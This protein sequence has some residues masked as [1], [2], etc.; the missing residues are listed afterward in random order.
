MRFFKTRLS[1]FRII[2]T[3][4]YHK[5]K[6]NVARVFIILQRVFFKMQ[7]QSKKNLQ[8]SKNFGEILDKIASRANKSLN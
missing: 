8:L 7:L 2:F 3:F 4:L 5:K 1:T 6:N